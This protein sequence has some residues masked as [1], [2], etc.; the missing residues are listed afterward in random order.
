MYKVL[1]YS[2][3]SVTNFVTK[4]YKKI[5]SV[6]LYLTIFSLYI[7]AR[8]I[9][10]YM[11]SE[12][13]ERITQAAAFYGAR[14]FFGFISEISKQ[15][16]NETKKGKTS[17]PSLFVNEDIS[18]EGHEIVVDCLFVAPAGNDEY[19]IY[20]AAAKIV[21]YLG[22]DSVV[23]RF[24]C[25]SDCSLAFTKTFKSVNLQPL[26]AHKLKGVEFQIK[27]YC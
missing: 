10:V 27:M 17:F 25:I 3:L 6:T 7:W 22:G 16:D 14:A 20:E 12:V 4:C 23:T 15:I 18:I 24:N 1:I 13:K 19:D 26:T 11:F 5:F 8:N 9:C 21:D 2:Y